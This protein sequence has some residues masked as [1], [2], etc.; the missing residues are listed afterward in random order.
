MVGDAIIYLLVGLISG[1]QFVVPSVDTTSLQSGMTSVGADVFQWL[2]VLSPIVDVQ[3]LL[4]VVYVLVSLLVAGL[5]FR[6][7]NYVFNHIPLIGA[8]G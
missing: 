5:A 4:A 1:V 6:L 2:S 3:L 8:F 7:A